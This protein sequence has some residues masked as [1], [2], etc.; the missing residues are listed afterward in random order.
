MHTLFVS[1]FN[2]LWWL[3]DK[4]IEIEIISNTIAFSFHNS[5]HDTKKVQ[6]IKSKLI[7]HYTFTRSCNTVI[8]PACPLCS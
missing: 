7:L 1:W 5:F 3:G 8:L 6:L 2:V 4:L